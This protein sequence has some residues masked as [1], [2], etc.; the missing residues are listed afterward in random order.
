MEKNPNETIL[1]PMLNKRVSD[2]YSTNIL[3]EAKLAWNEEERMELLKKIEAKDEQLSIFKSIDGDRE[4][5]M[6]NRIE[7]AR[8]SAKEAA[9]REKAEMARDF[10]RQKTELLQS[11]DERIQIAV[12]D[13]KR[14]AGTDISTANAYRQEA[15]KK[16]N[17]LL[18]QM[19][20]LQKQI[21]ENETETARLESVNATLKQKIYDLENP[22]PVSVEKPKPSGKKAKSTAV[23]G[24]ETY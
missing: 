3:L 17:I 24:G 4:T 9:E 18:E 10:E 6:N 19:A 8:A 7:Q 12:N 20:L 11:I 2:L 22:K 21:T 15:E 23:I 14:A 5:E 16:S 13:V 1:I